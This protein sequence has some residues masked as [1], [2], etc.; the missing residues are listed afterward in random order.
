MT[1]LL[2]SYSFHL[3]VLVQSNLICVIRKNLRLSPAHL[4]TLY[5]L[6]ATEYKQ[7]DDRGYK[8]ATLK[9]C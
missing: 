1:D 8:N 2:G 5:S 3:H 6:F 9:L 4:L 7:D